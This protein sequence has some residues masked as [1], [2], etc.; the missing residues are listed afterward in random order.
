MSLVGS[1]TILGT[2]L[3]MLS[4]RMRK[5]QTPGFYALRGIINIGIDY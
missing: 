2:A 1:A 3:G 4:T 5:L